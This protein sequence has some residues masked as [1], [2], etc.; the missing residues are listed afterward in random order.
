MSPGDFG[1]REQSMELNWVRELAE[2]DSEISFELRKAFTKSIRSR[3]TVDKA[4]FL[5][6]EPSVEEP[7][8]EEPSVEEPSG[9]NGA[10]ELIVCERIFAVK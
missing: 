4:R 7:S 5:A 2:R 10:I 8:V 1:K 6:K 3:T 9:L